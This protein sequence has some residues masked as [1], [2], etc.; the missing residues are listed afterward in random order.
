M[1][2]PKLPSE[3]SIS[4]NLVL[5]SRLWQKNIKLIPLHSYEVQ[6]VCPG[7]VGLKMRRPR[8]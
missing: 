6:G 2:K 7:E 3:P 4:L 5:P 1:L 8:R